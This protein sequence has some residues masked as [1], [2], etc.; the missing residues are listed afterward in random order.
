[1][2][3]D[4]GAELVSGIEEREG[5]VVGLREDFHSFGFD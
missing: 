5:M 2:K 1:M 4:L 3:A